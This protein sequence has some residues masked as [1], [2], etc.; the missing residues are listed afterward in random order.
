MR[1]THKTIHEQ[2]INLTTNCQNMSCDHLSQQQQ[3]QSMNEPCLLVM[4]ATRNELSKRHWNKCFPTVFWPPVTDPDLSNKL[5][6]ADLYQSTN[7]VGSLGQ[8][9]LQMFWSYCM[10]DRWMDRWPK[11]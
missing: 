1:R 6:T 9:I 10:T 5:Q 3:Q 7:R 4:P 11:N 8:F 2:T